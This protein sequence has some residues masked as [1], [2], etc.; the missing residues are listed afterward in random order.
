MQGSID[1]VSE[2]IR[3][4][5]TPAFLIAAVSSM[6]G[7]LTSRLARVADQAL[8]LNAE[9]SNVFMRTQRSV[10]IRD[11]AA[12]AWLLLAAMALCVVSAL[13]VTVVIALLYWARRGI[14]DFSGAIGP[15]FVLSIAMLAI[16]M[17]CLL[18]EVGLASAITGIL[19]RDLR[20]E[21]QESISER[22]SSDK[23]NMS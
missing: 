19:T 4:A 18:A 20:R 17:L 15:V 23:E 14:A 13:L 1:S 5:L 8:S 21:L 3:L 11:I 22:V 7:V 10:A 6:L 12:R 2:L 9:R 16:A